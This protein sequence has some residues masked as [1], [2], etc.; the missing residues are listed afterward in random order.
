MRDN[1]GREALARRC[2]PCSA[3]GS[4][5]ALGSSKSSSPTLASSDTTERMNVRALAGSD[6][7]DSR[8]HERKRM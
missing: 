2:S 5:D 8:A 7:R 4:S 3:T 6:I 1:G